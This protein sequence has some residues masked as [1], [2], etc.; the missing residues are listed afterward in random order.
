MD[1]PPA[2]L[3]FAIPELLLLILYEY[4]NSCRKD[5]MRSARE[6]LSQGLVQ[7]PTTMHSAFRHITYVPLH[8]SAT[9]FYHLEYCVPGAALP[10]FWVVLT[11]SSKRQVVRNY[12]HALAVRENV[13]MC[14]SGCCA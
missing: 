4:G 6:R 13:W 14:A 12:M 11:D 7:R 5:R 2:S 1:P 9:K 10:G 3:V 8:I